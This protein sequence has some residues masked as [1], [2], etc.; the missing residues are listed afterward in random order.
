M[1]RNWGLT[2]SAPVLRGV[3]RPERSRAYT[4]PRD[5][6]NL[7]PPLPPRSII[8]PADLPLPRSQLAQAMLDVLAVSFAFLFLSVTAVGVAAGGFILLF[9]RIE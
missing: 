3:E 7:L 8:K 2:T 1:T 6:D 9:V 5:L 4:T